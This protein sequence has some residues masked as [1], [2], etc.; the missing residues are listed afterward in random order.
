MSMSFG[1]RTRTRSVTTTPMSFGLRTRATRIENLALQTQQRDLAAMSGLGLN[2]ATVSGVG[3][4]LT[5]PTLS[6]FSLSLPFRCICESF[7]LSLRVC[8]FRKL[9][10]GKIKMEM[11]LQGQRTYFTV[12]GN[13]FPFDPIFL[14]HPNTRIYEKAFLEVI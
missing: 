3:P 9:F 2:L 4:L 6:S 8:E 14:A 12:N 5:L 10:E 13:N 11:L 7:F 1:S